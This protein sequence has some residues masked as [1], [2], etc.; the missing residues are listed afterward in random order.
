MK[1]YQV[2]PKVKKNIKENIQSSSWPK[3][4]KKKEGKAHIPKQLGLSTDK[5]E[6]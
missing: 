3:Q 6:A 1:T 2:E 4:A 5:R